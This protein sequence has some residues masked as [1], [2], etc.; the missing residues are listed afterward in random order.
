MS[1]PEAPV[2]TAYYLSVDTKA[3]IPPDGYSQQAGELLEL[4]RSILTDP[5]SLSTLT[6]RAKLTKVDV[7]VEVSHE[8]SLSAA[9]V[10]ELE[11]TAK[12]TFD[13][14]KFA[15]LLK[16]RGSKWPGAKISKRALPSHGLG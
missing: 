6:H 2:Q 13:K 8:G 15:S 4:C 5:P 9:A 11:G 1:S 7:E 10:V 14:G 12:I 3:V 16:E